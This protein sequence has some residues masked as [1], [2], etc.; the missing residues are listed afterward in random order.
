MAKKLVIVESPAKAKTISRFLGKEY[1]VTASF[2][3]VRDLPESASEVPE[4]FKKSKWGRY[5]V[6]VDNNFKPYYV[7][8]KDKSGRVKDLKAAAKEADHVLLATDEDREGESISWHILELLKPKKGTKVERIVFHEI[9]PEAIQEALA[10]PRQVDDDLVRAQEAR[11]IVDRLFGYTLSPLLWKKVG[12]RLSAG[13]V[14]S[15]AVRLIVMRERERAEFVSVDYAGI[16]V[17][18]EAKEGRFSARLA[19]IDDKRVADGQSFSS[20]GQLTEKAAKSEI[21]L[22][23]DDA[24]SIASRLA[25]A[26]P[27]TI[28][29]VES[30]PGL[31]NPPPPFMTS[32]LQQE[33][34]RKFG[35]TAKRTMQIAQNLYEGVDIGNGPTGLITYMRTD[36]LTLA[37]RALQEARDVIRHKYGAEYLPEK[38][39]RYA[40]KAKN[41]QEAHEAIRPTDLACEPASIRQFLSDDQ[42]KIYELIWKRTLAC[43][44]QPARVERTRIEVEVADPQPTHGK[45]LNFQASG[46]TITFPGFLRAYVE[47]SDDPDASLGDRERPLPAVRVGEV[48]TPSETLAASGN[49]VLATAHTTRPP[50]RYTEASLVK[51]LEEEGVGRPSTY[52]SIIGTIQERDYVNKQD[53]E[54]V[55]TFTAYAVTSLLERNFEDLVDVGFTA[56]MEDQLDD[57]ADGKRDL[58]KHLRDFFSGTPSQPGLQTLVD[59][60]ADDIPYFALPIGED[61]VVRIGRN[62]PFL[63]Q[64]EGGPGATASIPEELPPA[65]LTIEKAKELLAKKAVEPAAV[66][67]HEPTGNPIVLRSGR[68]GDYYEVDSGGD[69]PLRVS[70][71]PGDSPATLTLEDLHK[72]FSFPVELGNHPETGEPVRLQIGR[73]GAYLTSGEKNANI[74]DWRPALELTL[75]QAVAKLAEGRGGTRGART[76]AAAIQEFGEVDGAAGP[77]KVLAGRFGPYVTDGTTNATIPRGFDPIT[78]TAEQAVEWI[79]A[80]AAAGPSKK[81]PVRR[82][83]TR[84]KSQ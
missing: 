7:V 33:A 24:K 20:V 2:G 37:E 62:G 68:Y 65:D 40:S 58:T 47:G 43:Q 79:K 31:E 78:I 8:P 4:E 51:K 80:K 48:V 5:G 52:A 19:K 22:K 6:D 66:G 46:K 28:A 16:E 14:Q 54:L 56:R 9:T 73:Y 38:P 32:T 64:G 29:T 50:A 3:H 1:T 35:F 76:P 59:A 81:R 75:D 69:K 25:G 39:K 12:P 13:R 53:K 23:I 21:W 61:I 36:S 70:V 18:L 67:I 27:W 82:K 17:E 60:K 74:G 42:F 30:K 10:H 26:T 84:K 45:V 34:N 11:R 63:Q 15:V 49:P 72:L 57:I 41:A 77:V 71:P 44:M 83:A 55:P